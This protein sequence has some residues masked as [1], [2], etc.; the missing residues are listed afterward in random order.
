MKLFNRFFFAL[1]FLLLPVG[2]LQAGPIGEGRALEAARAFFQRDDNRALR[3]APLSRVSL[4]RA[5]LTK[6]A[7]SDPAFYV[8]NRAGGGFVIIGGDDACAPVL[9]Y[10]FTGRFGTGDDMPDGLRSWLEDLEEQVAIARSEG[11]ASRQAFSPEWS[12]IFVPTKGVAADFK[13]EVKYNTPLWGQGTPFNNLAPVIGENR[14]V[15]GCV[16]LA[17]SMLC[18]FYTYPLK[19]TGSLPSYSYTPDSG[20]IQNIEGFD[21]G[22]IYD[23][24][25]MKADYKQGYSDAEAAAV[26]RL[27]YDCGV[28]AQVTFDKSTSG[29]INTMARKAI[30]HFGF[31]AAAVGVSRNYYTD[32]KWLELIKSELQEHPVLYS[33]RREDSGHAFLVDGYDKNGYLSVNWG[34]SGDSNGYYRLEAFSPNAQRQY[35]YKHAAILGL[36]PDAGGKAQEYLYLLSGKSS[37]GDQFHGL[38]ASGAI[39]ARKDFSMKVGGI[40]NGGNEIFEGYYILALCDA[41]GKIKDFVCGSQLIDP[42][43]PR[44]W[45]GY[46]EVSCHL[47]LYPEEG[48]VIKPFY[49]S[50]NWPDDDWRTF[51]YDKT[52]GTVETVPVFDNQTLAQATDVSYS[53]TTGHLTVETKDNVTWSL[54]SSTGASM[55]SYVSYSVTTMTIRADEMPKGAYTLTL[56]RGE[57]QVKLNLKMGKK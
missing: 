46:N 25:N 36:K 2:V 49:R 6:A 42:L 22:H 12:A 55:A 13:P 34:W 27:V 28:M 19:G 30:E 9:G 44:Y 15:A 56:K 8:F 7:A 45:R 20:V 1:L 29:N 48:D 31:D 4:E 32:V 10:S 53:T 26:S 40:C 17:M 43:Q 14:A 51:L 23:W 5:P 50:I 54:T 24:T 33:A 37:S 52:D 18:W 57:D 38:E 41:N 35:L 11:E 16:P 47:N 39:V 21:L 3:M